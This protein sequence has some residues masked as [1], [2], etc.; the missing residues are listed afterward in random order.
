MDQ[1]LPPS[2][3]AFTGHRPAKLGGYAHHNP[4]RKIIQQKIYD[5]L[6]NPIEG[7][8]VTKA[9][10]GMALGVDQWAAQ[11]CVDLGIPFV[12]A[13]PCADHS[14]IWPD[15]A[16]GEYNRLLSLASEVVVVSD[17]PYRHAVMQIRNEWMVDN[18][19]L[20]IAVW[21]GSKGGTAN[22][23]RYAKLMGKRMRLISDWSTK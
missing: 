23:I 5:L 20:L 1:V 10:S 8:Q 14:L 9:I 11:V 4:A 19:D 18:S 6:T 21:D 16:K 15:D 17:G 13:V 12:A 22:C 2:T 7:C 3:V